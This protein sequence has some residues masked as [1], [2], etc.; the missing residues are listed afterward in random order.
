MAEPTDRLHAP[1]DPL[2]IFVGMLIE[3]Q[4]LSAD[5]LLITADALGE[6]AQELLY[7]D[8][9]D[10]ARDCQILDARLRAACGNRPPL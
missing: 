2:A 8:R 7:V 5:H 10:A 6:A 3:D 1:D 9:R 4:R